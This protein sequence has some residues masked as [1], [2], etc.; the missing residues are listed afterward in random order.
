[1]FQLVVEG[2]LYGFPEHVLPSKVPSW[3]AQVS[4]A[5]NDQDLKVQAVS[6]V[7]GVLSTVTSAIS[8]H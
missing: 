1:M 5:E 7:A 3:Q 4:V 8:T 6:G 2:Q